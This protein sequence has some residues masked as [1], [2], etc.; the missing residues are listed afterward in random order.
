MIRPADFTF[1]VSNS[2]FPLTPGDQ[3]TYRNGDVTVV[4]TVTHQTI[5]LMGVT[6]TVVHDVSRIGGKVHEDTLDYYA[7][8]SNGSVWYFGEDTIA[9]EDGVASTQGSWR[10]GVDGAKPGIVMPVLK[11]LGVTNRE[12]FRLGSAEDL[13]RNEAINRHV[14][15]PVGTFNTAFETIETTPLEPQVAEEKYYVP[16]IGLVLTVDRRTGEREELIK[17]RHGV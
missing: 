15:V 12:E 10:A 6:C 8:H 14:V 3:Y 2:Y 11:T 7:Q 16:G 4:V 17:A 9:Y 13:A 1:N 5:K